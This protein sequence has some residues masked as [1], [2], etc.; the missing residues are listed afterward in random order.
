MIKAGAGALPALRRGGA[1]LGHGR[2]SGRPPTGSSDYPWRPPRRAS[3]QRGGRQ[4]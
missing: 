4:P 3:S 1:V 2:P